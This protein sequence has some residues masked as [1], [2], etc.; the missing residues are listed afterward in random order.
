[1]ADAQDLPTQRL[2]QLKEWLR[3]ADIE[4]DANALD[5]CATT[6]RDSASVAYSVRAKADLDEEQTVGRIPKDSVLS[7]K[8]CGVADV[9][10]AA[11]LDG[12]AGDTIT[13]L[14]S[15]S[16]IGT[17]NVASNGTWS[18]TPTTA[19]AEGQHSLTATST[20]G[21]GLTGRD[22]GVAAIATALLTREG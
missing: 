17:A 10:E 2:I 15:N 18:I 16:L 1:M 7:I 4:Y 21:L 3:T 12:V 6:A 22:E 11:K 14:E 8:N 20:D 9:L 19:F 13:L 5:L